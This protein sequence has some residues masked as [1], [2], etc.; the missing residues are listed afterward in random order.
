MPIFCNRHPCGGLP[1]RPGTL[2]R[3]NA[4]VFLL[5]LD[6]VR[7]VAHCLGNSTLLIAPSKDR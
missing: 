6:V 3:N 2:R 1:L 7:L 5:L 4:I